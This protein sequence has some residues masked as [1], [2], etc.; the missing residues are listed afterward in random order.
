MNIEGIRK[1][2]AALHGLAYLLTGRRDLAIEIAVEAAV[3][4]D[5]ENPYFAGWMW[6]WAR[7]IVLAKALAAMRGE[8]VESAGRI[9]LARTKR[10]LLASRD[11]S[12]GTDTTRTDLERALLAIDVFPRAA[13]LLLTFERVP[14]AEASALLDAD[15]DLIR[16]A[17]AIGLREL[18]ANLAHHETAGALSLAH[19]F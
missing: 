8:L 17:Q 4:E 15:A 6:G 7:N 3:M 5:A 16:K 9:A 1:R 12:L 13:V 2:V 18:T 19:A 11:W 14:M 10:G